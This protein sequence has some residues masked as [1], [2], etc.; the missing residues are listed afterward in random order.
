MNLDQW[1]NI[2]ESI[3]IAEIDEQYKQY[4][5]LKYDQKIIESLSEMR[6]QS[7][8]L[9]VNFFKKPK[10]L[11]TT[12]VEAIAYSKTKK[13]ELEIH[14][15]RNKKIISSRYLFNN[16]PVNW[17]NWRQFNSQQKNHKNRKEVFDDFIIKTK[18]I[19][20]LVS[21]R[22]NQMK[23]IF[24]E[25]ENMNYTDKKLD[26]LSCYLENENISFEQ[27]VNFIKKLAGKALKPFQQSL[28]IGRELLKREPDYYDDFYFFRNKV[29]SDFDYKFNSVNP[30]YEV[31][32][33][34][35]GLGF[36]LSAIHFDTEERN[37]KYPSPICFFVQI[38]VDIR[39]L[40][41]KESPYFDLQGCFHEAGHA[42]H[43][44]SINKEINYWEKYKIPMGI[45]EIFSI[46]LERL[47]K[48]K[49]FI[50]DLLPSID[51]SFLDN[52]M[53]RNNFM[54]LFFITFYAA[55]SL[56]KLDYW[57]NNLS[58]EEANEA[59]S[60]Y[61]REYT[62]FD[63]PGEYWLLHHI[64]PESIMYV[65]SYLIAAV[66]AAELE[67]YLANKFG[68]SWWKEKDC[69]SY[70]REIMRPGTRI[71]LTV[72]SDLKIDKFTNEITKT[73]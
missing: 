29:F 44:V 26:P 27:L 62:G 20:P 59:Y 70:L 57:K 40:F 50:R 43:A 73:L 47:T 21:E 52:L 23:N 46:F 1:C 14:Q 39:I 11:F 55:N 54:E 33:V 10:E 60:K 49:S 67:Y 16:N 69:G 68:D 17:S 71:D 63:T 35:K 24:S 37:N 66:R 53:L 18:Y 28:D 7:S 56:M 42:M 5:G 61:I 25:Y 31:S 8:N 51:D 19:A 32:K 45:A 13:L 72:F 36:D 12:A 65:P 64:L 3:Y 58:I 4:A 41:K 6:I 22:F 48:N 15:F 2:D 30:I 9:F 34:L 38:P